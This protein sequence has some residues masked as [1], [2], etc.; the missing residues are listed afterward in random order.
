MPGGA[1]PKVESPGERVHAFPARRE[2]GAIGPLPRVEGRRTG[3]EIGQ[4][5]EDLVADVAT[6]G[7]EGERWEDRRGF[8]DGSDHQRAAVLAGGRPLPACACRH[9]QQHHHH[10]GTQT[11]APFHENSREASVNRESPS[12]IGKVAREG[13]KAGRCN[14]GRA[15]GRLG[16]S[17]ARELTLAHPSICPS[18]SS[19]LSPFLLTPPSSELSFPSELFT[20]RKV[21][22]CKALHVQ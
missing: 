21:W 5:L 15:V 12:N 11:Q 3:L 16:G 1:G 8:A 4:P 20:S 19:L 7:T 10:A 17:G 9:A 13:G 2:P 18:A 22:A 14:G 6:H